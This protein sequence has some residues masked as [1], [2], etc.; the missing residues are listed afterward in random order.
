MLLE[1]YIRS[2]SAWLTILLLKIVAIA[3][4]NEMFFRTPFLF[5]FKKLRKD[6]FELTAS[7]KTYPTQLAK[8]Y[9]LKDCETH[10]KKP[11]L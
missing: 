6:D 9:G 8:T 3:I 2:I 11:N 1:C 7:I 4:M 10:I 5:F